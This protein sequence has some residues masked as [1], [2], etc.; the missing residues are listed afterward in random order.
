MQLP[1][2]RPSAPQL[3][4]VCLLLALA[5][6][7]PPAPATALR[8]PARHMPARREATPRQDTPTQPAKPAQQSDRRAGELLLRFRM[9]VTEQE[10]DALIQQTGVQRQPLRGASGIERLT[11]SA[12]QNTDTIAATLAN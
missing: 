3:R 12:D 9:G 10:Q 6:L 7:T 11:L 2:A 5:I 8:M 4:F 1:L